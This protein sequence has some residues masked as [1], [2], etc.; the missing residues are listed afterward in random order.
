[1]LT[2]TCRSARCSSTDSTQCAS[3]AW[4]RQ[5]WVRRSHVRPGEVRHLRRL[6]LEGEGRHRRGRR[7]RRRRQAKRRRTFGIL[8][9]HRPRPTFTRSARHLPASPLNPPSLGAGVPPGLEPAPRIR[10]DLLNC[11]Q[12]LLEMISMQRASEW[13]E[14]QGDLEALLERAARPREEGGL[15]KKHFVM[16]A[17]LMLRP[18][19]SARIDSSMACFR[20]SLSSQPE[21]RSNRHSGQPLA[22]SQGFHDLQF[23]AG[24]SLPGFG[25]I[26]RSSTPET[27]PSPSLP[28]A[29]HP[30]RSGRGQHQAGRL[31]Q[32]EE[33]ASL[34]RCLALGTDPLRLAPRARGCSISWNQLFHVGPALYFSHPM[35]HT[36][37]VTLHSLRRSGRHSE[38]KAARA[39][40]SQDCTGRCPFRH[41]CRL[42]LD[43]ENDLVQ[44]IGNE[45]CLPGMRNGLIAFW[46]WFA[47]TTK[48]CAAEGSLPVKRHALLIP[49]PHK[50]PK[51]R[52]APA[53]DCVVVR[54][55]RVHK[56]T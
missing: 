8:T 44:A 26:L 6:G 18:T 24:T 13:G 49:C 16:H 37:P 1:M 33:G 50:L 10:S 31:S 11:E 41:I 9:T 35:G 32:V 30:A 56:P 40:R 17:A 34:H 55:G 14:S 12:I 15:G 3:R 20:S 22:W 2:T 36:T 53:D 51:L 27:P 54:V 21:T 7:R 42:V 4:F 29:T 28:R 25:R 5:R 39:T 47:R 38:C 23:R 48:S 45:I 52:Y 19:P 46:F 43:K